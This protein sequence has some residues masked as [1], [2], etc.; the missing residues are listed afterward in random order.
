MLASLYGVLLD[1]VPLRYKNMQNGEFEVYELNLS[2]F[3]VEDTH[4]N[5]N[6]I[7]PIF[8]T[9]NNFR[10]ILESDIQKKFSLELKSI[11]VVNKTNFSQ[12]STNNK[13][14]YFQKIKNSI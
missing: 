1:Y 11:D 7:K 14:F 2:N 6:C 5:S 9:L 4:Y 3:K 10:L 13:N 12:I 8:L